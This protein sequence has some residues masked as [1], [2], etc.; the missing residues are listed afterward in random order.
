MEKGRHYTIVTL[1]GDGIG[2]EVTREAVRVLEAAAEAFG[3]GVAFEEYA[4]GG[5]ALDAYDDPLPEATLAACRAA[6]AVFLGAVGGPAWDQYPGN[7]RPEAGLL[8]LRKELGVFANLRPVA[9]AEPGVTKTTWAGPGVSSSVRELPSPVSWYS[10]A[11]SSAD[12]ALRNNITS[13]MYPRQFSR[14][15]PPR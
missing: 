2:P 12:N 8:R 6:H 7:K 15:W 9:E 10:S 5:A 13:S 3:F 4:V 1:P 11:I 14:P